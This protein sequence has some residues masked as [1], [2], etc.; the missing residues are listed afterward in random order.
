MNLLLSVAVAFLGAWVWILSSHGLPQEQLDALQLIHRQIGEEHVEPPQRRPHLLVVAKFR[1]A[2]P[3][4][5]RVLRGLLFVLFCL[6]H[7][8]L[9]LIRVGGAS[10]LLAR[11]PRVSHNLLTDN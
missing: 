10:G 11:P 2:A 6:R 4:F 7:R 1:P 5:R 8:S 3:L 9:P